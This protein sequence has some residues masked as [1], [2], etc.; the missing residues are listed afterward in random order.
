MYKK[1]LYAV[2]YAARRFNAFC[3]FNFTL[4]L[5]SIVALEFVARSEAAGPLTVT[6]TNPR[7]FADQDGKAV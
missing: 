3:L 6:T 4:L 2:G 5:C 1:F 7:Y